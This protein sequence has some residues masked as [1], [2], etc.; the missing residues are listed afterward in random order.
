[1]YPIEPPGHGKIP[2]GKRHPYIII[3]VAPSSSPVPEG[4]MLMEAIVF[5]LSPYS[6]SKV[7]ADYCAHKGLDADKYRCHPVVFVKDLKAGKGTI[8]IHQ[9]G[10]RF[11]GRINWRS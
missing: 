6:G 11:L 4:A 10:D 5:S 8:S 7:L 2:I 1:M 9:N 3:P